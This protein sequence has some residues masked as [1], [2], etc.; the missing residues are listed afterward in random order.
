MSQLTSKTITELRDGFRAGEFSAREIAEAFNA[1][2]VAG[3]SLNA[4][5]VETPEL[6]LAAAEE[7]DRDRSAGSLKPLSGIPLG[8]KDL[9][10]TEGVDST[11]GSKILKG[12]KPTY[13]ST[14]SG[15][16]KA[17]GAGMLGKL[18]MDEFAMGSS[19]E[20]SA[21]GPVISPWRRNDGSNAAL[22]PGGS[23]G[24]SAAAVSA[25]LAP[26]VT[27]TDTGGSIRQPA[28]FTGISGIKPTYGRCSRWGI[29][30][31]AS[32]LDQAGPMARTVR[33]CAIML[34]AM[35]GFDPKD[36]TSLNL[37]VPQWEAGLS[38]DLKGKKV[39]IPKEYRIDGV[40]EEINAIWD[41]GIEWLKDAG[42]EVVEISLPHTR[43]ALPT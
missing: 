43:Y 14:V 22:T 5:T 7:A 19:N 2:V 11:S 30:A 16:L 31:F 12:F 15:N 3:R 18:N 40:P 34:E 24:G 27:G 20:T 13:E 10:A 32:S 41:Q 42:A 21:Y 25:G 36:A 38:S 6:A 33:D 4:Y 23:S 37:P 29:V 39:G 17:A 1:A 8:I 28:A 26:G 35:A 9:F